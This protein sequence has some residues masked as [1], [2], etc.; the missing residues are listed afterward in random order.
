MNPYLHD[1][2]LIEKGIKIRFAAGIYN[3]F[4]GYR[5]S[6]QEMIDCA[7][8][9]C[10]ISENNSKT[11]Y[12]LFTEEV[13]AEIARNEKIETMME[14]ALENREFRLF[15]QPKYDVKHDCI[16]SAEALVRWFDTEKGEYKFPGEFI[17]LFETNGFIVK[18]DHFVYIEVLE[19]LS[20]A[21][22][23]GDKV[24]PI[25]V[26]VSR[27][28]ATSPD[29]INFYV[30]NK[31]KYGIPD[32]FVTLELTESFAMESYDKISSIIR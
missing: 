30:G 22:E 14:S 16:H 9:A 19:Y 27:V 29:F 31:K 21:T 26:N 17:P 18:L 11:A 13:R 1:K 4:S 8:T 7:T 25:S 3:V 28:T 12:T 23:R 10:G 32:G 6:V 20:H 24:V 5:R 2:H 15:L